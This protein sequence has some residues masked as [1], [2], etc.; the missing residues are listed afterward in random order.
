MKTISFIGGDLRIIKLIEQ[1]RKENKII[2]TFGLENSIEVHKSE[3]FNNISECIEQ[4]ELVIS[5]VPFSK[6]GKNVFMPFSENELS[7]DDLFCNLG[8]KTLIAGSVNK[9]I[10][11]KFKNLKIIDLIEIEELTISNVIATAEGAIQIAMENTQ[12]TIHNSDI[13]IL[14]FG[15]IGKILAKDLQALSARV[16]CEARK[17]S[18]LSW[19]RAYG[20]KEL[21]LKDLDKHLNEFNII[22]NTIPFLILDKDRLKNVNKNCLIIDLSSKPGGVDF[23]ECEKLRI[24][25]ILALGL[26]G[27]VAPLT[28]AKYIKNVIDKII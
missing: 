18:D 4:S 6:D 14:G 20:Y 22:F 8:N 12:H 26:P 16:T 9:Y 7:I 27:K 3:K 2:K 1:Y 17:T 10:S 21:D 15:R 5:S 24:K 11:D 28:S 23:A 13:L 25:S 19:I